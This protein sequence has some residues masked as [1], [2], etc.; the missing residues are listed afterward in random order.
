MEIFDQM[1]FD[2]KVKTV[3]DLTREV[4]F[5]SHLLGE[6]TSAP[7]TGPFSVPYAE[8]PPSLLRDTIMSECHGLIFRLQMLERLGYNEVVNVLAQTLKTTVDYSRSTLNV[9]CEAQGKDPYLT[10]CLLT[11]S[12]KLKGTETEEPQTRQ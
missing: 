3:N 10:E 12:R 4:L 9:F 6:L 8:F 2:R 5:I 1:S 11:A 7:E